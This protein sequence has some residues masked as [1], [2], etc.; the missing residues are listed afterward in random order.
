MVMKCR[1]AI[2]TTLRR[3]FKTLSA[4]EKR[5][6]LSTCLRQHLLRAT[7]EVFTSLTSVLYIHYLACANPIVEIRRPP[8]SLAFRLMHIHDL[9]ILTFP[10]GSR[11]CSG[12]ELKV[13]I[14]KERVEWPLS[15]FLNTNT[16]C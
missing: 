13:L 7:T 9:Q 15:T 16:G 5:V 4:C 11:A 6:V 14:V 10:I 12:I 3:G 8:A 1:W 2:S